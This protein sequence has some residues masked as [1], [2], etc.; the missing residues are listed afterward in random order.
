VWIAAKGERCTVT[1]QHGK[2]KS[3]EDANARKAYWAEKL[4]ALAL[5]LSG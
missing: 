5:M 1:I 4:H 3:K 2:L